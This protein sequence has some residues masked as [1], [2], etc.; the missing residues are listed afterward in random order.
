MKARDV[1]CAL[2]CESCLAL[3]L[4]DGD[5]LRIAVGFLAASGRHKAS[6]LD[7]LSIDGL[8]IGPWPKDLSYF[9]ARWT[10]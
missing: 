5:P 7:D 1:R 4:S 6:T 10:F 2:D 3:P 8:Y 9:L